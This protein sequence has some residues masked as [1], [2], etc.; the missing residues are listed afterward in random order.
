MEGVIEVDADAFN[1]WEAA[2]W[3]RRAEAY[4][5]YFSSLTG[6]MNEPLL[7]I[8][9]VGP[10]R[11][12]LDV[13]CG[14]GHLAAAAAARGAEA[15]GVDVADAM[16]RLAT[17]LHPGAGFTRADAESLPFPDGTF[18]A[19]VGNLAIL[20]FG[21]PERAVAE[22]ARVLVPGGVLA[23]S[24]WDNP[25]VGRLPGIFFQAIQEAGVEAPPDLPP[26]PPFYR[27]A[28]EAEFCRLLRGAGLR[29]VSVAAV[30][31][32][33]RFPG[34]DEVWH[35]MLDGTVRAGVMVTAQPEDTQVRIRGIL[36]RLA[37][38]YRDG[39]TGELEIPVSFKVARGHR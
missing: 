31:F 9:T 23:L 2:G 22:F 18:D 1:A 25:A 39:A 24:T 15:T 32:S 29:D 35:W 36:D 20:H 5:R 30:A 37:E 8:A 19:V 14:P 28:D 26:G 27:F 17:D 38:E 7:D 11:R 34:V 3:E 33:H 13:A 21:R 10:G 6:R 12:V 4:H 16:V